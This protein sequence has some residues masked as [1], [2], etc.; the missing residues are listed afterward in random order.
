MQGVIACTSDVD[1][2]GD[3]MVAYKFCHLFNEFGSFGSE[4]R[5][6]LLSLF[7]IV[8]FLLYGDYC[9]SCACDAPCFLLRLHA[10]YCSHHQLVLIKIF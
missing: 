8:V 7:V 3:Y 10:R 6:S 4:F 9:Y 1:V 2:G 5:Q